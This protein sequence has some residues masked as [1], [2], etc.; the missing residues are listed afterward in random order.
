[1]VHHGRACASSAVD[2]ALPAHVVEEGV[3]RRVDEEVEVEQGEKLL[4]GGRAGCRAG[5]KRR[6][7]R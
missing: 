6:E 5:E 1:V 7:A 2:G 4:D 3:G